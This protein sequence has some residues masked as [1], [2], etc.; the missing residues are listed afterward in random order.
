M[1]KGIFKT[2]IILSS[3][4]HMKIFSQELFRHILYL[5][6][7]KHYYMIGIIFQSSLLLHIMKLANYI[8]STPS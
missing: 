7:N 1:G 2:P 3:I 5:H 6:K 4:S 8:Y